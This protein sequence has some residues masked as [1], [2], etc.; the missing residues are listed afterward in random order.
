MKIKALRKEL[1]QAQKA[2]GNIEVVVWA[3]RGLEPGYPH[4]AFGKLVI[5]PDFLSEHAYINENRGDG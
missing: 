2:Y 1:K 5:E 3:E 4:I